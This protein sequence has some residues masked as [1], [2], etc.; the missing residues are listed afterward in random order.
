MIYH[1][2]TNFKDDWSYSTYVNVMEVKPTDDPDPL[3][4]CGQI[5]TYV[6]TN[7]QHGPSK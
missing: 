1:L 5:T 3:C 7:L 2:T 4:K 6:D